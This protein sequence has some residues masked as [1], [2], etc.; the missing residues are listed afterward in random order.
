MIFLTRNPLT[1]LHFTIL[2][3]GILLVLSSCAEQTG[4]NPILI[5]HAILTDKIVREP[6][7][8]L[9]LR[10]TNI[11]SLRELDSF[12]ALE[13][14]RIY[15][16]VGVENYTGNARIDWVRPDG[17]IFYQQ[18]FYFEG[19]SSAMWGGRGEFGRSLVSTLHTRFARHFSG[20]WKTII[21]V[22]GTLA[23]ELQWTLKGDSNFELSNAKPG[24]YNLFAASS[25]SKRGEKWKVSGRDEVFEIG[26]GKRVYFVGEFGGLDG[27]GL[28]HVLRWEIFRPSEKHYATFTQVSPFLWQEGFKSSMFM[29]IDQKRKRNRPSGVWSVKAFVNGHYTNTLYFVLVDKGE[30][31]AE[32]LRIFRQKVDQSVNN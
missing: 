5:R 17:E 21:Y 24:T 6:D 13:H 10:L 11:L 8:S 26:D 15:A 29:R 22:N 7:T 32:Y 27:K 28:S 9:G 16:Y 23:E 20:E 2:L 25:V 4:T 18:S 19:E 3:A 14:K 30:D 31:R 1:R 12:D